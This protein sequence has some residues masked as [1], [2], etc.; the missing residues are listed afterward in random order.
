MARKPRSQTR[1]TPPIAGLDFG[2]YQ[3]AV[4]QNLIM[5]EKIAEEEKKK[6]DEYNSKSL[7]G[8]GL[9]QLKD[10][11]MNWLDPMIVGQDT[12]DLIDQMRY[13]N[14]NPDAMANTPTIAPNVGGRGGGPAGA[15]L[16]G[17]SPQNMLNMGSKYIA[18]QVPLAT[19]ALA[20]S[21]LAQ[22]YGGDFL[23]NLMGTAGLG[24]NEK[25]YGGRPPVADTVSS[26]LWSIAGFLPAG[27][28]A[29]KGVGMVKSLAKMG[30]PQQEKALRDMSKT[31]SSPKM[32][33]EMRKMVRSKKSK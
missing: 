20:R 22:W 9:S 11:Y 17:F 30:L 12:R 18:N 4:L 6:R 13:Y 14:Q 32:M 10:F 7:A 21:G 16:Q 27:S 5:Q 2:G 23:A 28:M 15:Y 25:Y 31:M 33:E 19:E 3:D 26:G 1:P 29:R 24:M 8:K